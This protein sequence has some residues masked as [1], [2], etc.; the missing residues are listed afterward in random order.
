MSDFCF[1]TLALGKP[2]RERAK[3]LARDLE[4]FAPG[5]SLVV[6]TDGPQDF[7]GLP[8]VR[9]HPHRQTGLFRCLNDKRFALSA[10]LDRHA[11]AAIFV[12]ADTR[13]QEALPKDVEFNSPITTIYT[14]NLA[15]Q[16]EKWLLPRDRSA[17]LDAARRFGLDHWGDETVWDNLF[18]VSRDARARTGLSASLGG[19]HES[20][21]FPRGIDYGWLLHGHRR[22][23]DWLDAVGRGIAI[24]RP[25][26]PSRRG[27]RRDSL[28]WSCDGRFA[29]GSELGGAGVVF[30]GECSAP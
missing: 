9:T 20:L 5:K 4:T 1:A 17:V 30:A 19:R 3:L 2:Y 22:R 11:A 14:P 27:Q 18:A 16:A 7:D 25:R 6:A 8:N 12:D 29:T 23:R 24:V 28:Q 26:T 13:I 15:E 21:R 10:A